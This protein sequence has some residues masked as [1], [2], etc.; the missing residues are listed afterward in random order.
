MPAAGRRDP[1]KS[2]SF[3]VEIDG[4]ASAAFKSVSGLAAEAE[5][6]EYREGSD[7]LSSSRKLPGRVRYPN[8][9]L[10]RG[11]T[12]SR[13]LWDWWQ[14]VVDGGVERRNVVVILLDDSRT[15]VL[16]WLLRNAW[17]ARIEAS[18]LDASKNEIAIE[19]VELAHEGLELES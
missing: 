19:T 3:L 10:R 18:E 5:V 11:L 9:T 15:P 13:D 16:R 1:Y 2:Y 17:I 12:T 14:T 4:I 7:V 8:V 6:I